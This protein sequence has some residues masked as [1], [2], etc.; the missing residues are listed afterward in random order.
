MLKSFCQNSSLLSWFLAIRIAAE[1][2]V[3]ILRS[4]EIENGQGFLYEVLV[5]ETGRQACAGPR[6]VGEWVE[7]VW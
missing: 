1:N 5:T 4:A 2:R 6:M 7:W 3:S